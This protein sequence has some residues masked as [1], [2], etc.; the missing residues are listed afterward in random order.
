[1]LTESTMEEPTYNDEFRPFLLTDAARE[2]LV[3]AFV[4]VLAAD[5]CVLFATLYGSAV[6]GEGERVVH[7]LDVALWPSICP[8]PRWLRRGG[9]RVAWA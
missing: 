5:E 4:P 1:M 8:N 3:A 7:D 2:E 6:E 9:P